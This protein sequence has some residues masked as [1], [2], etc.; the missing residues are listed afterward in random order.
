MMQSPEQG[1]PA[2][3]RLFIGALI[4]LANAGKPD[5]A[6]RFAARGWSV[7]RRNNAREAGRLSAALRRLARGASVTSH[8]GKGA[9][10]D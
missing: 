5:D 6:C 9:D 10:D 1:V 7:L 2:I 4:A 8:D 3:N